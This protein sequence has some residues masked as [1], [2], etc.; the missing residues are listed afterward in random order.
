MKTKSCLFAIGCLC[1]AIGAQAQGTLV[2][3]PSSMGAITTDFYDDHQT[4]TF[5][6]PTTPLANYT[7]VRVTFRAP[8]GYAWQVLPGHDF[9]CS[10]AYTAP[11][12]DD[13]PTAGYSFNFVP[14]MSSSVSGGLVDQRLSESSFGFDAAFQFVGS[15]EFTDL[16]ITLYYYPGH[17][18]QIAQRP[19]APFDKAFFDIYKYPG[20]DRGQHLFLV[21]VPEPGAAALAVLGAGLAVIRASGK[22]SLI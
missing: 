18:W 16:S 9:T 1:A 17:D 15:V 11:A 5:P 20:E 21:P 13:Y 10:V 12:T 6:T 8:D 7:A 22:S 2:I 14:G 3:T 19:M 4:F